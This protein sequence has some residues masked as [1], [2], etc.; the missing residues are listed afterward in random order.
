MAK[1]QTQD[2]PMRDYGDEHIE[3]VETPVVEKKPVRQEPTNRVINN[4]EVKDRRYML[5]SGRSPLSYAVRTR[6]LYYFDEEK[7]Y[8][9]EIMYAEN[10]QTPFVDEMTGQVRPGRI[11]F[12][13]GVLFVPKNKVMLQKF[14]SLY[15]PRKDSLYVEVKPSV[16]AAS[17]LDVMNIELDA[18]IAA[19]DMDIDTIEAIMRTEVGSKVSKMTSKELKRDVLVFAKSRP[20]LFLSLMKDD[21]IHLRN[22]GIK[23]CEQHII[24]LSSDQRTFTWRSTGRKL[25][26]VPFEEHPYSA[27]ASWFKTDEGMEV[28]K[29]V[30][31]QLK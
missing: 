7:G 2:S 3:K 25:L 22:L 13:N 15:H 14:L 27:L 20:K 6:G 10:Q 1:K 9:R 12:R 8:E 19:R 21:N 28:L 17:D 26:N 5:K 16:K 4:W 18:M 23:A 29:S 24:E 11:I 31:K 30:E